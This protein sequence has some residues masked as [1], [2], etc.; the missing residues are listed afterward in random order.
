MIRFKMY[1]TLMRCMILA[2]CLSSMYTIMYDIICAN[3]PSYFCYINVASS[4]GFTGAYFLGRGVTIAEEKQ[5]Y[6]SGTRCKMFLG[7]HLLHWPTN[8]KL[9]LLLPLAIGFVTSSIVEIII[10]SIIHSK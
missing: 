1:L 4:T 10:M 5:Y 8:A 6:P 7:F 3:M 2:V 9:E